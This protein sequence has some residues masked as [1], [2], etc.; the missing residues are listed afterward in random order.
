MNVKIEHVVYVVPTAI[1][2]GCKAMFK[3]KK[4]QREGV[5]LD[6]VRWYMTKRL[7][8]NPTPL[9]LADYLNRWTVLRPETVANR[10]GERLVRQWVREGYIVRCGFGRYKLAAKPRAKR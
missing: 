10:L 8:L 2:S 5:H 6:N 1:V 4:A 7:A 3:G 9:R